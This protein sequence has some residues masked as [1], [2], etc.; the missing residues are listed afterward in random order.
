MALEKLI[1][2]D[3]ELAAVDGADGAD[4]GARYDI[5]DRA[6]NSIARGAKINLVNDVNVAGTLHD[7][8]N[9]NMLAQKCDAVGSFYYSPTQNMP[10]HSLPQ[11][12]SASSWRALPPCP[13]NMGQNPAVGFYDGKYFVTLGQQGNTLS[14]DVAVFD[15]AENA[16]QIFPSG[17]TRGLNLG[18]IQDFRV[19][20][21]RLLVAGKDWDNIGPPTAWLDAFDLESLTWAFGSTTHWPVGMVRLGA[22]CI[23]DDG[24]HAI[25]AGRIS[26]NPAQVLTQIDR[27]TQ[28]STAPISSGQLP[29]IGGTFSAAMGIGTFDGGHV[30]TTHDGQVLFSAALSG[31]TAAAQSGTAAGILRPI[32]GNATTLAADAP[33]TNLFNLNADRQVAAFNAGRVVN[34]QMMAAFGNYC[35]FMRSAATN[36]WLPTNQWGIFDAT[37]GTVI[38]LA[39]APRDLSGFGLCAAPGAL[40]AAADNTAFLC[41][42]SQTASGVVLAHVYKGLSISAGASI[43]LTNESRAMALAPGVWH[44]ADDDYLVCAVPDVPVFGH[45][46][47]I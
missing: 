26:A 22:V 43:V 23:A 36:V 33:N 21:G 37:S 17:R 38:R 12:V 44:V 6:G 42:N 40:F 32:R 10:L 3:E 35:Y 28:T 7:A 9:M 24:A 47:N 30:L 27:I 2:R 39:D 41:N 14:Y 4:H 8:A 45:I 29:F 46:A 20:D 11:T 19:I 5:T 1:W 13:V 16:W 25:I 34:G 18:G 31:W 15:V